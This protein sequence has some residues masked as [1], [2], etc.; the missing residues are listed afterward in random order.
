MTWPQN[1]DP[2]QNVALSTASSSTASRWRRW[3]EFLVSL[4]AYGFQFTKSVVK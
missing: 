1:Y 4:Q 2:L 3:W